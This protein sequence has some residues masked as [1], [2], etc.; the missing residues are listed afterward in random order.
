M[1]VTDIFRQ[2]SEMSL[3]VS[4][5]SRTYLNT[6]GATPSSEKGGASLMPTQHMSLQ[7]FPSDVQ[8]ALKPESTQSSLLVLQAWKEGKIVGVIS[9]LLTCHPHARQ[10]TAEVTDV[11]RARFWEEKARQASKQ[12][13]RLLKGQHKPCKK[14]P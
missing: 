8:D 10:Q 9:L 3:T 2:H 14:Y 7:C 11:W 5:E 4:D 1:G 13:Q 6:S 12:I